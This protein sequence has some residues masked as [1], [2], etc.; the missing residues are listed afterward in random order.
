MDYNFGIR[1]GSKTVAFALQLPAKFGEVV[2]FAVVRDPKRAVLVAHRHVGLGRKIKNGKAAAAEAN[3]GTVG[4]PTLP[5]TGIIRAAVCLDM[6]HAAKH[7]LI[8]TVCQSGNSTHNGPSP[9]LLLLAFSFPVLQFVDLGFGVKHLNCLK[10][11]IDQAGH[12]IQKSETQG[13]TI[14]EKQD[15]RA[16][17]GKE[18]ALQ[19]ASALSLCAKER[20]WQFRVFATL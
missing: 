17:H 5:Q 2:D 11:A 14:Q 1:V 6:R 9:L 19:P 7:F 10:S 4:E 20:R 13:I 15:G 3:I 12:A 16:R 18:F 8:A